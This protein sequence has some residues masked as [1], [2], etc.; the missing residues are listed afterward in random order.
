MRNVIERAVLLCDTGHITPEVLP[1]EIV[2]VRKD[3]VEAA[4]ESALE[5]YE[6]AMIVKA[7]EDADWNQTKAARALGISRDNLRYR[8]RKYGIRRA[9]P[10]A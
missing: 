2:G 10:G 5:G 4:D 7:L 1:R 8:L 6:K 3:E 9:E